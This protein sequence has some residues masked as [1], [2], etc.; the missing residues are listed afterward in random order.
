MGYD[1]TLH[2]VD[3]RLVREQF[4]PRLLSRDQRPSAFDERKDAEQLWTQVRQA[5]SGEAVDEDGRRLTPT[6]AA[7]LVCQLAVAYCAAEL[8]Y[9]YERGFCLSLWPDQPDRLD[10]K[11]PGKFIGN[12]E[13]LFG[14]VL[15]AHPAL[16]GKF[17]QEILSN[18]CTGLYVPAERVAELLAWAER[19]VKRYPKPDRRLFRGLLLVLKEAAER[20]VGYW[21]G[22]EIPVPMRTLRPAGAGTRPELVDV[23]F[24]RYADDFR[25]RHGDLLVFSSPVYSKGDPGTVFVD[26]SRWPPTMQ[27]LPE[28]SVSLERSRGGQWVMVSRGPE[29]EHRLLV[30]LRADDPLSRTPRLLVPEGDE[31]LGY[32]SWAGFLGERVVACRVFRWKTGP[33]RVPMLQHGDVLRDAEGEA[34]PAND[35]HGDQPQEEY[36]EPRVVRLADGQEMLLCSVI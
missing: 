21:E 34:R 19:R 8:P 14:E 36:M 30:R 6:A 24:P 12:P 25:Y 33:R 13:S 2:V 15:Q 28:Q 22:T 31:S 27:V 26:L 5:L 3:E 10:A 20:K 11:V 23:K 17:P 16:K 7:G 35:D 9:H 29:D 4:V 32:A 18:Y 1:C